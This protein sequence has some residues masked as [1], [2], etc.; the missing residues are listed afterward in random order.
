MIKNILVD[1]ASFFIFCFVGPGLPGRLK[2]QKISPTSICVKWLPPIQTNGE[3][4]KYIL[5]YSTLNDTS[6]LEISGEETSHVLKKLE[7]AK[8]YR[9]RVRAATKAGN[10]NFTKYV[11][12]FNT[13]SSKP[14]SS[15]I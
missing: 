14:R 10:G 12:F 4:V 11:I 8:T 1:L 7:N 2:L 3:I 15:Y 6:I 13:A 5:E 9:F